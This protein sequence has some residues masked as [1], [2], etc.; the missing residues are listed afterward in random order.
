MILPSISKGKDVPVNQASVSTNGKITSR[1]SAAVIMSIVYDYEV[2]PEHDHFV[3]LFERGNAL[4]M[5]SLTP[6]S[7]SVIDAFPFGK[8]SPFL[9][10]VLQADQRFSA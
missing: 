10:P 7:L 2:A 3:E 6:E 8:W 5:E 4:A 9:N 1:F